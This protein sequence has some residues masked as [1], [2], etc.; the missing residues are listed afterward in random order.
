MCPV[1]FV[2]RRGHHAL[3]QDMQPRDGDYCLV[4]PLDVHMHIWVGTSVV[5]PPPSWRLRRR[6][7]SA[8]PHV[9]C[10]RNGP[11]HRALLRKQSHI[12]RGDAVDDEGATS[13]GTCVCDVYSPWGC[14]ISAMVFSL[15]YDAD[16]EG[17]YVSLRWFV[18]TKITC[19]NTNMR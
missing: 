12:A 3:L 18:W 13:F 6:G 16:R 9:G 19:D 15:I 11:C 10:V 17:V 14:M 2:L 1:A 4:C 7:A 5:A 8:S